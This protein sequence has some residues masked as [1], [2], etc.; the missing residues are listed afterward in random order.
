M[1]RI[2]I[3]YEQ[4]RIFTAGA[5]TKAKLIK[6]FSESNCS[7]LTPE[8]AVEELLLLVQ[9]LVDIAD[10]YTLQAHQNFQS[11][12]EMWSAKTA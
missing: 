9:N 12:Y 2:A 3:N 10:E 8:K 6:E 11:L 1:S 7:D 5:E 4:F